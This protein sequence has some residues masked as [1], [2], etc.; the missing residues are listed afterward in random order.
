MAQ[1]LTQFF[2]FSSRTRT[3]LSWYAVTKI[4]FKI[5]LLLF[6]YTY[7]YIHSV[8]FCLC[9]WFFSGLMRKKTIILKWVL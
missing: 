2:L 5:Y 4:H 6:Q 1:V 3:Q 8:C 7:R 9:V